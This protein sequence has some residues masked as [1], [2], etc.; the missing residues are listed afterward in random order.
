MTLECTNFSPRYADTPFLSVIRYHHQI[1]T[2]TRLNRAD[3]LEKQHLR[4]NENSLKDRE[5]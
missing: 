2:Q 5:S 3:M 4:K 1:Y